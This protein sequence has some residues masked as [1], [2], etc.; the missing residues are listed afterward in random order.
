MKFDSKEVLSIEDLGEVDGSPVKAV[1][2]VGGLVI[3]VKASGKS[4]QVIGSASHIGLLRHAI[5]KTVS[6]FRPSLMKSDSDEK[7]VVDY[8][9]LLPGVLLKSNYGLYAISESP[10]QIKYTLTH[11]SD[12]QDHTSEFHMKGLIKNETLFLT[13]SGENHPLI[14]QISIALGKAAAKDAV[15]H[16]KK[17]VEFNGTRFDSKKLAK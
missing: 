8:S 13:K 7:E 9:S 2:L 14:S 11:Q 16:G 1:S 6:G 5:R 15:R 3:G 4:S 17:F 10:S 12:T